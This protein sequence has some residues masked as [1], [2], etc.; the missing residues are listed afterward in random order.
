MNFK[1]LILYNGNRGV[2][3]ENSTYGKH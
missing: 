1:G 2:S 3:M